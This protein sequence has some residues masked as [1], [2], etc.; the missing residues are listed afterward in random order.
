MRKWNVLPDREMLEQCFVLSLLVN[1]RTLVQECEPSQEL[2]RFAE[3]LQEFGLN[4]KQVADQIVLEGVGMGYRVPVVLPQDFSLNANTLILALASKNS[5]T[6]YTI[7]ASSAEELAEK[8]KLL[9]HVAK[10]NVKEE[11]ENSISFSFKPKS[12]NLICSKNGSYPYLQ[13]NFALLSALVLGETLAFDERMAIRDQWSSMLKYFG[14]NLSYEVQMPE[15]K[16]EFERRL[17]KAQG[18]KMIKTWKTYLDETHTLSPREYFVPG[19]AT[20]A[21]AY[22]LAAL[23]SSAPE[24]KQD[25]FSNVVSS[26]SRASVFTILKRMG[27]ELDFLGKHERYGEPFAD[28]AVKPL[29]TKRLQGCHFSGDSL[30]AS[31]EE[32]S[33]LAVAAC[34][35]EKETIFHLPAEEVVRKRHWLELLATNLR[36]TGAE[37]GVYEDG[38]VVRG[39][40]EPD[41]AEFDCEGY[42]V[43]GLALYV[44]KVVT[45]SP[46]DIMG[47]EVTEKLFPNALEI[48]DQICGKEA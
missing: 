40:E 23:L 38:L 2:L 4:C 13:R 25:V 10:V 3:A 37:I 6:D 36:K 24:R 47:I 14:V 1:G 33:V 19:D 28:L 29:L 26:S 18:I 16:D 44:L 11:T 12:Q 20:L 46:F 30:S 9:L 7:L 34:F 39:K 43:M 17:A 45:K 8:K 42:P 22:A 41:R 32:I 15:F 27:A 48:I 5:D 21:S 35:A 31:I